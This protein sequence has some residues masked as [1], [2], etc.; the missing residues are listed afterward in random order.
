MPKLLD[1][2][3]NAACNLTLIRH[4]LLSTVALRSIFVKKKRFY[5]WNKKIRLKTLE[6]PLLYVQYF[7]K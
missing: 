4:L 3:E 1:E 2:R 5:I 7:F 6:V